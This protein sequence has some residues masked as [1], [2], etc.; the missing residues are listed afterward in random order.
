MT[1]N[2]EQQLDNAYQYMARNGWY[3]G[4]FRNEHGQ[5]CLLGALAYGN[6]Y[7][8]LVYHNEDIDSV[9]G[10]FVWQ[11]SE[12]LSDILFER[13]GIAAVAKVND[14]VVTSEAEALGLLEKAR[15]RAAEQGI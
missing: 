6:A 9:L 12:C 7:E 2:V 1:R 8:D 10:S 14:D 15:A 5:V 13:Y 11:A 3:Q 4:D